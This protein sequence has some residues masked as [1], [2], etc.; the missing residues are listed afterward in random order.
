VPSFTDVIIGASAL[1]ADIQQVIDA[2]KGT[3]GKGVPISLTAVNDPGSFAL[4]VRNNDGGASKAVIVY[5]ADGTILFQI[6]KNGVLASPDGVAGASGI[7]TAA[8][9][10]NLTG[11]TYAA[12]LA[13][14]TAG[15]IFVGGTASGAPVTGTFQAGSFVIDLT[16]KI[17][18]CTVAG[19][20]GTWV[21]VGAQTTASNVLGADVTLT[22]QN[23]YYAG[24]SMTQGLV[25]TWDCEGT[26]TIKDNGGAAI[27]YVKLWDGVT[28]IAS[29]VA[30]Q[31]VGANPIT[32]TLGG[33]LTTPAGNIRISVTNT[34]RAGGS[35]VFNDSAN[36][37]D[38]TIFGKRI[39]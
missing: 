31:T 16:G 24:P 39:G 5:K 30:S 25:G 8:G 38:S 35:I 34:T 20:P 29:C 14:A 21:Q 36:S 15:A 9:T 33:Q 10:L 32:V 6:D 18:V 4:S 17:W 7:L 37:K 3:A 22:T 26:V 23:T 27:F 28:V 12:T 19:S 1:A 13:G 2:L 11:K